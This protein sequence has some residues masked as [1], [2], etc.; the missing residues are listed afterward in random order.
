MKYLLLITFLLAGGCAGNDPGKIQTSPA[1]QPKSVPTTQP[2]QKQPDAWQTLVDV[3]LAQDSDYED[4]S[5]ITNSNRTMIVATVKSAPCKM[6]FKHVSTH[7]EDFWMP[8]QI[9]CKNHDDM[10]DFIS[11]EELSD[12]RHLER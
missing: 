3:G 12:I 10:T 5:F 8:Q 7:N 2:V 9:S 4:V 11:E 1:L 6:V